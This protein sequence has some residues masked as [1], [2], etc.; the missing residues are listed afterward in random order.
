M[1]KSHAQSAAVDEIIRSC[2]A[3]RVCRLSRVINGVYD[4]SLKPIGLTASQMSILVVLGQTDGA[5]PGEVCRALQMDKSTLSRNV[6]RMQRQGWVRTTVTDDARSHL[7]EVTETGL[8]LIERALP[9][10]QGAQS[11]AREALGG[12]VADQ[13]FEV[14]DSPSFADRPVDQAAAAGGGRSEPIT[15]SVQED[16]SKPHRASLS[17]VQAAPTDLEASMPPASPEVPATSKPGADKIFF[18]E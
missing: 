12:E 11:Q 16:R 2:L 9:L 7:L 13:L 1:A 15:V 18:W 8:G 4:R 10:W 3:T 14:I 6:K 5:R 17:A